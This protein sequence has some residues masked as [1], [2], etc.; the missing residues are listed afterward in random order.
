MTRLLEEALETVR[1]LP[2]AMQDEL[3]RMLL[4]LVGVDQPPIRLT[5]EEDAALDES[6][7]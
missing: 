3:A 7:A 2:D 6:L 5:P 4:Q 1:V